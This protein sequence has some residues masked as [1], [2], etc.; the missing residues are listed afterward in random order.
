MRNPERRILVINSVRGLRRISVRSS[1]NEFFCCCIIVVREL[2]LFMWGNFNSGIRLLDVLHFK[3]DMEKLYIN[4]QLLCTD[5]YS[6][7]KYFMNK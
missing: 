2:E 3:T 1:D 6:F 5:Y 4:Y 7:I